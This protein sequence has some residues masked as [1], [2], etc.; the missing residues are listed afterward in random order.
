MRLID[1][2]SS[3]VVLVDY[4]PKLMAAIHDGARVLAQARRLT[5]VA[6]TLSVPV[7]GTQQ[8][9]DR[10]GA[11]DEVLAEACDRVLDKM[12]FDSC[13]SGLLEAVG[14]LGSTLAGLKPETPGT[15]DHGPVLDLI[16]AGCE[17]HVCLL[18]T[19]LTAASAGHRVWVVQD[20]CGSRSPASHQLAMGRLRDAGIRVVNVEMVAFEWLRTAEHRRFRAVQALIK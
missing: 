1:M 4:Q 16:M 10:L 11:L 2:T 18:Q 9:P 12:T 14:E 13:G 6:A 20:A 15:K 3:L 7:M 5:E 8:N 17:A 19:A